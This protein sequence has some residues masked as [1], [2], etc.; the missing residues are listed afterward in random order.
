M[1]SDEPDNSLEL[2]GGC[3]WAVAKLAAILLT[4]LLLLFAFVRLVKWMWEA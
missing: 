3:I 1:K 2:L 4:P